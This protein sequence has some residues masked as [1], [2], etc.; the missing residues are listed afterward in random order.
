MEKVDD[1]EVDSLVR[2]MEDQQN[3][4]RADKAK[5]TANKWLQEHNSG[6]LEISDKSLDKLEKVLGII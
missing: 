4:G 3:P 5:E 1:I 2:A 6:L